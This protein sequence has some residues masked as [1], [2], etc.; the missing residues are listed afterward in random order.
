MEW[1]RAGGCGLVVGERVCGSPVFA[2]VTC[3][4]HAR[5]LGHGELA[6][7]LGRAARSKNCC[8]SISIARLAQSA[9]RKALNLVVVGSSPTVGAAFAQQQQRARTENTSNPKNKQT[10]ERKERRHNQA[11]SVSPATRRH[12][13]APSCTKNSSDFERLPGRNAASHPARRA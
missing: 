13:R 5:V 7:L 8:G 1:R 11:T 2:P 12:E 3:G 9:E 10:R 6:S 4:Q